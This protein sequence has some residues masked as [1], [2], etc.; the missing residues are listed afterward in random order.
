MAYDDTAQKAKVKVL[1]PEAGDAN[2][3]LQ[4]ELAKE[5]INDRRGFT[6]TDE[7]PIEEKYMG[8]Q[9]LMAVEALS[10]QGAEGEKS[11]SD[12]GVNRSYENGSPYSDTLVNRIIPLGSSYKS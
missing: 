11:H 3:E 1:Y 10:K 5:F 12:N 6:P 7:R 8:L 4:L 2:I 9:V